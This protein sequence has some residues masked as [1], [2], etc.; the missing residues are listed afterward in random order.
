MSNI[1]STGDPIIIASVSVCGADGCEQTA[2]SACGG[3][4]TV[5][6]C[7]RDCQKSHW[8]NGHKA[9]CSG[10]SSNPPPSNPSNKREGNAELSGSG[11]HAPETERE[12]GEGGKTPAQDPA[13]LAQV[14]KRL[15]EL[16]VEVADNKTEKKDEVRFTQPLDEGQSEKDRM[17]ALLREKIAAK[18]RDK[19]RNNQLFIYAMQ[20]GNKNGGSKALPGQ[21]YYKQNE[22]HDTT[23]SAVRHHFGAGGGGSH[24]HMAGSVQFQKGLRLKGVVSRH[25]K[26]AAVRNGKKMK[27]ASTLGMLA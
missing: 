16:E 6:Y 23:M 9:L 13:I 26:Q 2:S 5:R 12:E 22:A 27:S 1:V 20:E 17:A 15:E 7:C 19:A 4:G 8:K 14:M 3:C 10:N 25:S 18:A 24:Y 11:S 21:Y